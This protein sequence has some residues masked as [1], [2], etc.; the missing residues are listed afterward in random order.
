M[1][2]FRAITATGVLGL[3]LASTAGHTFAA[4]GKLT[5]STGIDYTTGSYGE[6]IDTS[7]VYIPFTGKYETGP[8]LFSLTLP[9]I[10]VSGPG[11]VV[12]DVG[13]VGTAG[14]A[15]RTE[16]GMGDIVGTATY[17][18]CWDPQR[19]LAID[20]TGKLKLATANERKNLGTG[21]EDL[22]VQVD[23][24]QSRGR[25]TPFGTLGYK[26]LGDPPGVDL[27]DVFYASAGATYRLDD[28]RI[29]GAMWYGQQ[30]TT[31]RGSA[32]SEITGFYSRK[33][34]ADWR[35]QFYGLLGL[36]DGSPDVGLGFVATRQF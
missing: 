9:Y 16:S 2:Q 24:Y 33:L 32:Q 5:G 30:K 36:S 20:F 34:D 8:W 1:F 25:W 4:D 28:E 11:G 7:I 14:T 23:A 26:F 35:G 18:Y 22:H 27:R 10:R 15:R 17:N 6:A 29:V 3:A 13:S 21:E 31:A 19:Q 12:R